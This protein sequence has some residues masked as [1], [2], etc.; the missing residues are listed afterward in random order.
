MSDEVEV[1]LLR[2]VLEAESARSPDGGLDRTYCVCTKLAHHSLERALVVLEENRQL[3]VLLL[4][5]LVLQH[6][7]DV[8]SFQ[9]RLELL[10]DEATWR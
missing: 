8:Q 10:C 6:K 9:L 3:P 2:R 1:V 7:V 5:P 4:Q